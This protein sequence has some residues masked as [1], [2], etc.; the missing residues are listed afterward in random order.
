MEFSMTMPEQPTEG[1]DDEGTVPLVVIRVMNEVVPASQTA[2][3]L[4]RILL[5]NLFAS[6]ADVVRRTDP[7]PHPPDLGTSIPLCDSARLERTGVLLV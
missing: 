1:N 3:S 5:A 4:D 2:P 6:N 7:I